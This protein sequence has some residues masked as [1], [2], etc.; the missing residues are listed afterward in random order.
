M[1][2]LTLALIL[3]ILFIITSICFIKILK[4]SKKSKPRRRVERYKPKKSSALNRQS[5][6]L[7]S[8]GQHH[9]H[10]ELIV[11]LNESPSSLPRPTTAT[12]TT[13]T[14][15]TR[16]SRHQLSSSANRLNM[17]VNENNYSSTR[18]A[19]TTSGTVGADGDYSKPL[20][21]PKKYVI[22]RSNLNANHSGSEISETST[23]NDENSKSTI[24]T[25]FSDQLNN[26]ATGRAAN[27]LPPLNSQI[28]YF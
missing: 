26:S 24:L 25:G 27:Y 22:S 3:A 6:Q 9:Q 20:L 5:A 15:A 23:N 8:L 14:A 21:G 7:H 28:C 19:K 1:I 16:T 10:Q 13:I 4:R 11:H 12:S 17:P 18:S 2:G